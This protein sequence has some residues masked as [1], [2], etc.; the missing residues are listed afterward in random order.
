MRGSQVNENEIIGIH[1]SQAL[2]LRHL[3]ALNRQETEDFFWFIA[4]RRDSSGKFNRRGHV[5]IFRRARREQPPD[6]FEWIVTFTYEDSGRSF[7][8]I[9]T[10]RDE[11]EAYQVAKEFIAADPEGARIA[12]AG[13]SGWTLTPARGKATT[14]PEGQAEYRAKSHKRARH[15]HT[16]KRNHRRK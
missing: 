13:F 1:R 6:I 11:T 14:L 9:V 15:K 8:V 3:A 10:A 2:A 12:S 16:S 7:D 4:S 5:F